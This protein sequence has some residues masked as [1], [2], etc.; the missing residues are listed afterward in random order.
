[1]LESGAVVIVVVLPSCGRV[2]ACVAALVIVLQRCVLLIFLI[3]AHSRLSSI[4]LYS[5]FK[6]LNFYQIYI[7]NSGLASLYHLQ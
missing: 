2:V 4:N 1:M 3:I 6:T 7:S 5:S